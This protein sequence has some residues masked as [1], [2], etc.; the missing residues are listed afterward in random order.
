MRGGDVG[1]IE[2]GERGLNDE[3][4]TLDQLLDPSTDMT[5]GWQR[6]Q[7]NNLCGFVFMS[8]CVYLYMS[9]HTRHTVC[10]QL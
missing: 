10:E 5:D 2:M 1:A 9:G 7:I 6:V 4:P 3:P 8:I